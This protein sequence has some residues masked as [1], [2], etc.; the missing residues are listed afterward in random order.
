MKKVIVKRGEK[1]LF[2]DVFYCDDFASNL[3][4]L[5]FSKKLKQNQGIILVTPKQSRLY[6][7]IHMLFV[8]FCIY[9]IFLDKNFK[10]VDIKKACPFAPLIIP[11]KP[12]KYILETTTKKDLKVGDKLIIET[13]IN[14]IKK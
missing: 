2:S 10:I 3:K 13:Y 1:I 8:F 7:A 9:A 4:G 5:M 6:S 11:K 14:K 12:S